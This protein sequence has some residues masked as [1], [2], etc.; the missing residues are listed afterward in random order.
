M[1][2][3]RETKEAAQRDIVQALQ[4]HGTDYD[5]TFL[6]AKYPEVPKPTFYRWV[7]KVQGSGAYVAAAAKEIKK[8]AP[9][10]AK[11][12]TQN[13]EKLAA[14]VVDQLPPAIRPED[15]A[16]TGF[17]SVAEKINQCMQHADKVLALCE[18]EDG[19]IRN[20]K[21]YLQASKHMLSAMETAAKI[22]AVLMD[23]NRLEQ[24]HR[25]IFERL[26]YRDPEVVA[27]IL[28]DLQALNAQWGI[29]S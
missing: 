8:T 23:A 27:L 29:G 24:F 18:V 12:A 20:P 10:R 19:R 3:D 14:R 17:I 9:R 15:V 21:L 2:V 13:A 6:R 28:E 25:A 11:K 16:S 26:R 5:W 22:T 1:S 4:N 7:Q